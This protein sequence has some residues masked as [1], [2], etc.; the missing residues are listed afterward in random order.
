MFYG[1]FFFAA[2]VN[3]GITRK[4]MKKLIQILIVTLPLAF[5]AV[6]AGNPTDNKAKKDINYTS[7]D[8]EVKLV[9]EKGKDG[10]Q[11]QVILPNAKNYDQVIFEKST[12]ALDNFTEIKT[13]ACDEHIKYDGSAILDKDKPSGNTYYRVVTVSSDGAERTYSPVMV[14]E[15]DE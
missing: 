11:M 3:T 1:N 13:V 10:V 15:A 9:V 2:A 6:Y 5:N 12:S 14:A 8:N 7:P 4:P